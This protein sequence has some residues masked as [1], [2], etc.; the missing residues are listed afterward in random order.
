MPQESPE[1]IDDQGAA[2]ILE[3]PLSFTAGLKKTGS[4]AA[5]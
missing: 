4:L 1:G 2:N 5:R 3:F